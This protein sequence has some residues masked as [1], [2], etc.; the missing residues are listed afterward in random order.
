MSVPEDICLDDIKAT[1][2]GFCYEVRPHLLI[3]LYI[4][5]IWREVC[6]VVFNY[7]KKLVLIISVSPLNEFD[8]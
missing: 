1:F 6:N 8:V 2:L 3:L 5:A 4:M 7:A